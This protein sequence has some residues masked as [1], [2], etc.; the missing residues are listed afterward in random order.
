MEERFGGEPPRYEVAHTLTL[1]TLL[2][3]RL[4]MVALGG[5]ASFLPRPGGS[6]VLYTWAPHRSL[7]V[8]YMSR[9]RPPVCI[10]CGSSR[11]IGKG[12]RRTKRWGNRRIRVCK[13]CGRKFT[14]RHQARQVTTAL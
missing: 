1:H 5:Y 14:P 6:I 10:H 8:M 7:E 13:D 4:F 2:P 9:G 3:V 12:V 11:S